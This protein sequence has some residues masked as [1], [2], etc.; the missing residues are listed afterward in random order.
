MQ[1]KSR[2][3]ARPSGM[4]RSRIR[5]INYETMRPCILMRNLER[6]FHQVRHLPLPAGA[7]KKGTFSDAKNTPPSAGTHVVVI[8]QNRTQHDRAQSFSHLGMT[9]GGRNKPSAV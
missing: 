1:W 5:V 4:A 3:A 7:L 6:A 9:L 8:R 2:F